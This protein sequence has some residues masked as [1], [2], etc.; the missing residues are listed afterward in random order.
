MAATDR[1]S[2]G[3]LNSQLVVSLTVALEF[4]V[5]TSPSSFEIKLLHHENRNVYCV[6][7]PIRCESLSSILFS[8]S[9]FF[10]FMLSLGIYNINSDSELSIRGRIL[11]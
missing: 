4:C 9:L 5:V 11:C 1:G 2:L 7:F 10:E 8:L 6:K 3:F